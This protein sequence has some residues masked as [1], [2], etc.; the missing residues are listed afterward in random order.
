MD[1]NGVSWETDVLHVDGIA[2]LDE[3]TVRFSAT[4][5]QCQVWWA[6]RAKEWAVPRTSAD[7]DVEFSTGGEQAG[8]RN[9]AWCNRDG[10]A[11]SEPRHAVKGHDRRVG[12]ED[13]S[14]RRSLKM[15]GFNTIDASS[16]NNSRR[17]DASALQR[18]GAILSRVAGTTLTSKAL[19]SS[20]DAL[21]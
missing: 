14:A 13:S 20:T 16:G 17:A 4:S 9:G 3:A 21:T 6:E 5:G 11:D 19:T 15:K 18:L 8:G 2:V 1:A 7:S 10:E 12:T